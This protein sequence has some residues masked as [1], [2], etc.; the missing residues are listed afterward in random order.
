MTKVLF[1]GSIEGFQGRM[2]GLIFRRLP[3]GTT[4]V[5]Q[6]PPKKNKR[7]KKRA[8]E[9]RSPRQKD[10]NERFSDSSSYAKWASRDNP[11]YA[12]LAAAD[13]MR[14]AYNFAISDW[15]RPPVIHRIQRRGKHIRVEATDNIQVARVRVTVLDEA[16]QVLEKG[17]CT[18]GKG[19]WWIFTPTVEGHTI[20]AE[21]WDFPRNKVSLVLD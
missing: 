12:E 18:K 21:A 19:N 13:P 8:K 17:E 7:Q 16:G 14:N 20:L 11:V 5:T 1:H 15:F 2:G 3:D 6:A 9:K 10:H 4:V